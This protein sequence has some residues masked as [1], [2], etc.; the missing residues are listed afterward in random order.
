MFIIILL[1]KALTVLSSRS[2]KYIA[3]NDNSSCAHQNFSL[4]SVT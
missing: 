4:S 1:R 2:L 3:V